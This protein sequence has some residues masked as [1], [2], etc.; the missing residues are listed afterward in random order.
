[1]AEAGARRR[2]T[3]WLAALLGAVLLAAG[4]SSSKDVVKPAALVEIRGA[5]AIRTPWRVSVG[6]ARDAFLQPAVLENAIYAAAAGGTLVRLDPATGRT[7]WRIETGVP[8]SAGVG[9]DG[10]TT[11]VASAKGEVLAFGADGK[12][13]WKATVPSDVIVPPLVGRGLVLVLSTDHRITAFAADGGR[14]EWIY[15]RQGPPLSL[16]VSTP[17]V[18]DGESV[19][20][21]FPGGRLVAVALAN[22]ALRWDA[23]VSEPNGATEVERLSDV[24]GTIAVGAR[25][26]CAASYQ[27]RVL[28]LDGA[29][30]AERWA[31]ALAAGAGVAFDDQRVFAVDQAATVIAFARDSGASVWRN[32]QLANRRLSS[33]LAHGGWIAVGDYQGYA[34]FLSAAD[35]RL[36]G[37]AATDGSAIVVAPQPW[38]DGAVV[39]TRD[40][41]VALLVPGGA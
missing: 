17:L 19:I 36:I 18:F 11:A 24:T 4:C 30:A 5:S 2:R 26:L 12:A 25:E 28:C 41:T 22:G 27:G 37:R 35:G 16:R 13:L 39:Q 31:R 7:V 1:M 23:A 34:H 15:Q 10:A 33:P 38:A 32:G 9:S 40:G 6:H 20:G 8:I 29:G 3:R 14:R 21:G